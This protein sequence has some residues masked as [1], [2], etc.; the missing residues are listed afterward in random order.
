M[1]LGLARFVYCESDNKVPR[2]MPA[3][4]YTVFGDDPEIGPQCDWLDW[5]SFQLL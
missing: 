3:L 1:G 5:G 2:L 4:R